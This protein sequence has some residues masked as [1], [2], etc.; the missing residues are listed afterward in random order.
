MSATYNLRG[1]RTRHQPDHFTAEHYYRA[2]IFL[3]VVDTQIQEINY[4][5]NDAAI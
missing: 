3:V 5:F 1:A 2:Q 4:K